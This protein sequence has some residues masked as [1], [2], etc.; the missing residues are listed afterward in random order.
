[1]G[2]GV[3][4]TARVRGLPGPGAGE[5][6]VETAMMRRAAR[7]GRLAERGVLMLSYGR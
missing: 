5:A 4:R 1:M 2:K 6:V 3:E 7:L